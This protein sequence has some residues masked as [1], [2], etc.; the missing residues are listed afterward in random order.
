MARARSSAWTPADIPLLDEAAEE[1]GEDDQAR[2]AHERAEAAGREA[3]LEFAHRVASTSGSGMVTAEMIAARFADSGPRLT[4]AERAAQDRT[5]AYGH[6]VVD[7]AQELSA[8]AWR[9]L[10]RRC[11]TRSMTVVGDL[12]QTSSPAGARNWATV[13]DPIL[14]G[15]WR[16][17]ELT[18][19]YRTPAAVAELA[20]HVVRAAGLVPGRLTS[21]RSGPDAVRVTVAPGPEH[22]TA[23]AVDE[24]RRLWAESTAA[25]T[26]QS[27][28]GGSWALVDIL[29]RAQPRFHLPRVKRPGADIGFRCARSDRRP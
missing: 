5:W 24:T 15:R 26:E 4:T 11:P 9:M 6:I 2:R 16:R 1:L 7:E 18:V 8:M 27:V 28:R 10:V 13:L 29:T 21:A 19:N 22:L 25:G 12:A 14:H 17:A 20:Q 23:T 3:D